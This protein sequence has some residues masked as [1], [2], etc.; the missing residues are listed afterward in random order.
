MSTTTR[1]NQWVACF[2]SELGID[3]DDFLPRDLSEDEKGISIRVLSQKCPRAMRL[4]AAF[5]AQAGNGEENVVSVDPG[6]ELE[7]V[8]SGEGVYLLNLT[9]HNCTRPMVAFQLQGRRL[10]FWSPRAVEIKQNGLEPEMRKNRS[11]FF[12]GV[13]FSRG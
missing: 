4:I 6:S 9:Y 1:C 12:S 5:S 11:Y 7:T 10:I 3:E 8:L 2:K 13:V